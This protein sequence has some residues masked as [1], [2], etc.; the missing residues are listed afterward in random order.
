M[1]WFMLAIADVANATANLSLK[2]AMDGTTRAADGGGLMTLLRQPMLWLAL[3]A[4]GVLLGSYLLAIRGLHI[5]IAYAITTG[6]ALVL[7][8]V[9]STWLFADR[10]GWAQLVGIG[11]VVVGVFLISAPGNG[12]AGA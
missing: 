1:H 6:M 4:A 8:T 9:V 7:M 3:V 2:L 10:L 11:L 5:S 12:Q